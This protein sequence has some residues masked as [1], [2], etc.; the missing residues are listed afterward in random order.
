MKLNSQ[1]PSKTRTWCALPASS[2]FK[3]VD[4]GYYLAD[5]GA[6]DHWD[7]SRAGNMSG[8]TDR[9]IVSCASAPIGAPWCP[10]AIRKLCMW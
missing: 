9:K 6:V 1:M 2:V 3:R 5:K 10:T 4:G 7:W 8:P